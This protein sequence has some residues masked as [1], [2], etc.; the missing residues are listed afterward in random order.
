MRFEIL[1]PTPLTR[2]FI[3]L[4]KDPKISMSIKAYLSNTSQKRSLPVGYDGTPIAK[5]GLNQFYKP[6]E[7]PLGN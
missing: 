2:R 6:R 3:N 1:S 4:Q 5:F 7:T